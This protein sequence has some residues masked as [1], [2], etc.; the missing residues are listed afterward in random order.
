MLL[1]LLLPCTMP[2]LL[3]ESD[4]VLLCTSLLRLP[5]LLMQGS[6]LK[7]IMAD[8][9]APVTTLKEVLNDLVDAVAARQALLLSLTKQGR[10]CPPACNTRSA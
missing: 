5:L 8:L 10:C 3:Y 7:Q 2:K 1:L 4:K 9:E 6:F